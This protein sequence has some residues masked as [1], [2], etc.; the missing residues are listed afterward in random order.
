MAEE[1]EKS[2]EKQFEETD[3]ESLVFKYS[4][5]SYGADYPVDGLVKRMKDGSVFVPPFQRNYVWTHK[6]ASRFVESLLLGLPVPGIFVSKETR[7]NK[8][9]VIDGQQRLR[10]LQ[11]FYDGIFEPTG[12]KFALIEVVSRLAEKTYNTLSAEDR[13]TLDDAIIHATVVKQDEPSSDDSSIYQIFERLNTGG[14]LL[15][16]QEIRA[17][18]YR[19]SLN[20][21]LESL[22]Q[23][24][25]WRTIF[26]KTSK[27]MRDK[28]LI[29]RFFAL[30]F[31]GSK[32]VKPMKEF[33]NMFMGAR[34]RVQDADLEQFRTLFMDTV[35]LAYDAIGEK[36]FRPVK[37]MNAAVFDSVMV[38]LASRLK[39]GEVRDPNGIRDKY[40]AL[41]EL[42]EYRKAV[43]TATTDE[44]SVRYRIKAA[45]DSFASVK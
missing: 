41:L 1:K 25:A 10:T 36:A 23:N 22:N 30:Y 43:E 44:H 18:I 14:M 15:S 17:C 12:R 42:P 19:G 31:D 2:L 38:G 33:L 37:A 16:A 40:F 34:R 28:E 6:K 3:E 4:I 24:T 26:G 45:T 9:L 21:L 13:R 32:Y 7:T 5:T 27:R 39:K 8:L 29:L 20:D 11:F 35:R